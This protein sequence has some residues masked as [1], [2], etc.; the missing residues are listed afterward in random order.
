MFSQVLHGDLA[1]RNILLAAGNIAKIADF[2]YAKSL[3]QNEE[4]KC[5]KSVSWIFLVGTY[6]LNWNLKFDAFFS[7]YLWNGWLSNQSGTESF[8]LNLM[9][10]LLVWQCGKFSRYQFHH[11][12]VGYTIDYIVNFLEIVRSKVL[13]YYLFF[14]PRVGEWW[15]IW[16]VEFGIST[17]KTR[18]CHKWN[19]G[20][21]SLIFTIVM[22]LN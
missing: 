12:L 20:I 4:Y 2:G 1:A 10:G 6:L 15:I 22:F 9:C 16:K 18:I 7:F 17:G 8:Q 5:S 21:I 14:P 11:T 3:Y 19:V 13:F